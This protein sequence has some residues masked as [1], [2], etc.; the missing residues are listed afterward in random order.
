MRWPDAA[1]WGHTLLA[2]ATAAAVV[3]ALAAAAAPRGRLPRRYLR[4]SLPRV[5]QVSS[6]LLLALLTTAMLH[7]LVLL[8]TG[9]FSVRYVWQH[10][11]SYQGPVRR[12]T[13]VLAGQE[14]SFLV[15]AL[16]AAA[17][18]AWTAGRWR[19]S[20]PTEQADAAVVHVI[21]ASVALVVLLITIASAPFQAFADA[22]PS[23]DAAAV[24]AEG[25]GLN[26][27]LANPWMPP[28]TLLTFASYALIGLAFA[29][30]AM[31]L[32]RA[33][34]G[35]VDDPQRWRN[36][37]RLAAR[38]AWLLL[39]AGL[40]TG[41]MWAYEEMTFGWFWSWDPVEAAT[42]SVWLLLTAALHAGGE[43]G[44]RRQRVYAPL[45]VT[46][47]FVGVLFASFVTR[48]GLHPSVHAFASGSVGRYLGLLL[49][50][51]VAGVATL[52]VVAGRKNPAA[53]S[54]RPWL[55]WA[56]WLLLAGAGLIVWG[57]AYPIAAGLLGRTVDLDTGFFTMWGFVLAVCLLLLMGFGMQAS[58]GTRRDAGLMLAFF[59]ALTAVAAA[60]KPVPALELMSVERRATASAVEAFLGRA[61]VLSLLP[62]AVYALI[63]VVE[64]W[65]SDRRTLPRAARALRTGSAAVHVG[66]VAIILGATFATLLSSTVTV[67]VS[68]ATGVGHGEG[69]T[70]HVTDLQRSEHLDS[71]GTLVEERE[72]AILEVRSERGLLAAGPAA[73]S[74]YPERA[75]GR[76]AGVLINRGLLSDTQVIY[77]GVAELRGDGVAVT[78]RRIPL[79]NLLWAGLLLFLGGM[80]VMLTSPPARP[81]EAQP[82]SVPTGRRPVAHA[83]RGSS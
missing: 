31:Q 60:V 39:S 11:A 25:R 2:A 63:A 80:G 76:H 45:L 72:V 5:G 21:A 47:S 40:L 38:W 10:S 59:V 43:T 71:L 61:S 69:I 42:L 24:P 64:R 29:I 4:A 37:G 79:V 7:L 78:I 46:L 50:A 52:A 82:P 22:F 75:M 18:A 30:A 41:V 36:D 57:L 12:M 17:V 23:L 16:F 51:L 58:R 13:A 9:D 33:A 68:P 65:W 6:R 66:V 73:V 1:V 34:Q 74:T 49:A 8:A 53:R 48:S 70:V 62:P 83:P 77:H 20:P 28:H 3:A 26:P 19:R 55:S 32:L 81:A 27:V 67:G 56:A 44:G 35:R 54:R 15:W 14:G